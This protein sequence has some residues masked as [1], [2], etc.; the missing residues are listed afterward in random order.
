[1]YNNDP[2]SRFDDYYRNRAVCNIFGIVRLRAIRS[3]L[4]YRERLAV[5]GK[6]SLYVARLSTG[7]NVI[8]R[9]SI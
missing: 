6:C 8:Q 3:C 4:E 1:M 2:V 7:T 9:K 5:N